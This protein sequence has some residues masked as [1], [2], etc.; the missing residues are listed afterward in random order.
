[1]AVVLKHSSRCVV[2]FYALQEVSAFAANAAEV[3]CFI[4]IVQQDPELSEDL[5]ELAGVPHASPQLLLFR[6]GQLAA[7][8]SHDAVTASWLAL[9][10]GAAAE[11]I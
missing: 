3:P 1:M 8:T 9:R 11:P 7:T 10:T 2:S 6:Y 5:E 4:V